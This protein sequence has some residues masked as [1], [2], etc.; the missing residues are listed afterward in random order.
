[1]LV[2]HLAWAPCDSR[3]KLIEKRPT[4]LR[5]GSTEVLSDNRGVQLPETRYVSVG[6]SQVAYQVLGQGPVDLVFNHGHC[7]IDV[8]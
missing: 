6:T 7:H 1:M 2:L 5:E 8:H 3:S 4:R